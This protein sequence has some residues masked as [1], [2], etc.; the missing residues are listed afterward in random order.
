MGVA[1]FIQPDFETQTEGT[2][3]KEAIDNAVQVLGALAAVFAAHEQDTPNMTVRVDAGALFVDGARVEVA[4]QSTGVI[5]APVT[6]PRIDRVVIDNE[7]GAVSMVTGVEA[8]DPDPPAIPEGKLPVAQVALATDTTE[9]TNDLLTDERLPGLFG[10]PA[11]DLE[12]AWPINS[13]HREIANVNPAT[14]LGFGTWEAL[15]QEFDDTL[16]NMHF[17]GSGATFADDGPFGLSVTASGGAT[18]SATQKKFGSKSLYLPGGATDYIEVG[19]AAFWAAWLNSREFT[20]DLWAY[21]DFNVSG[22]SLWYWDASNLVRISATGVITAI[23]NGSAQD[24]GTLT[25]NTWQHIRA[26]YR[27][28]V[29]RIALDGTFHAASLT[30][31]FSVANA[32]RIGNQGA[33]YWIGYLDEPKIFNRALAVS[34]FTPPTVPYRN[35]YRWL[36]TA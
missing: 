23:I 32:L 13:V 18:Q 26:V 24:F 8:A 4:A 1:T 29:L 28:G 10:Q 20:L 14:T 30:Q 11:A 22:A 16:L 9:I 5:T 27:D 6:N 36:R 15:G 35:L 25:V 31:P 12:G 7:T 34:N 19:T 21:G 2:S 33:Y 3:Y 17:E